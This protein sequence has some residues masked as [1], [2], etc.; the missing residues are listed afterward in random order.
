MLWKVVITDEASAIFKGSCLSADDL[1]TIKTWARTVAKYGPAKLLERPD[2]W[3]DHPL[4]G[5][6]AGH[7]SSS[8]SHRGRIIYRIEAHVITVVVVRI[9]PDHDY[10]QKEQ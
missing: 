4:V 6:W 10:R 5:E 8:F 7:R 1:E 9:T 3:A 2:K